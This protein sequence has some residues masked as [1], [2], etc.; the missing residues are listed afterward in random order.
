MNGVLSYLKWVYFVMTCKVLKK[1]Y[2][3]I[4]FMPLNSSWQ[5]LKNIFSDAWLLML[6]SVINI[7]NYDLVTNFFSF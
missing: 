2:M 7:Y 4:N 6:R 5:R 3:Q 1:I